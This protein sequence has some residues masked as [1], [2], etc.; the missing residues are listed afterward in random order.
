MQ[1]KHCFALLCTSLL[2]ITGNANAS[3]IQLD[4][5]AAMNWGAVSGPL[6]ISADAVLIQQQTTGVTS[7]PFTIAGSFVIDTQAPAVPGGSGFWSSDAFNRVAIEVGSKQFVWEN[8]PGY[9]SDR[10]GITLSNSDSSDWVRTGSRSGPYS[11]GID[12]YE[13]PEILPQSVAAGAYRISLHSLVFDLMAPGLLSSDILADQ[14]FDWGSIDLN[15]ALLNS[16][17]LQF[18]AHTGEVSLRE[19]ERLA[20]NASGRFTSFAL[21]NLPESSNSGPNA[22][23]EPATLA[24]LPLGLAMLGG[25]VWRRRRS[26]S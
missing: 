26:E 7:S 6:S 23:P 1:P 5:T 17:S 14:A 25:L 2:L 4:F 19:N 3:L 16:L 13:Y 18:V 12:S 9:T 20:Q 22:V 8:R 15:A 11:G 10:Y 21:H 24:L